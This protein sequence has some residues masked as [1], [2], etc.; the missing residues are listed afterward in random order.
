MNIP[1]SF[2]S[3]LTLAGNGIWI[4]SG[5]QKDMQVS[6]PAEGHSSCFQIEDSSFWFQ[7]RNKVILNTYRLARGDSSEVPF[8][9]L[10]GGNGVVA[11]FLQD[12]GIPTILIEPGIQGVLNARSRGVHNV[13]HGAWED[14]TLN[15]GKARF[16][17]GLFDVLEHLEKPFDF[18]STIVSSMEEGSCVLATVPAYQWL[19]SHEDIHAG[20]F[21]RYTLKGLE[22]EFER[23]GLRPVWSSGF[24][25]FLIPFIFGLRRLPYLL[26]PRIERSSYN[27]AERDHKKS[28]FMNRMTEIEERY[29]AKGRRLS[30]G[31]SLMCLAR[32]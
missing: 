12:S 29:L 30:F 24:F 10:G 15:Q 21:R 32:K 4:R 7:H 11:K 25:V 16:D 20:H 23:A 26:N 22:A 2:F 5:L 13:I 9:D 6:Y 28:G 31:A 14:F 19:W 17:V 1:Q 18:L 8:V 3:N 27:N